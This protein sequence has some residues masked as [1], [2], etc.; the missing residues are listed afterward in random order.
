MPK[1]LW[2][3]LHYQALK[4]QMVGEAHY[5]IHTQTWHK[6]RIDEWSECGRAWLGRGH[7]AR[8]SAGRDQAFQSPWSGRGRLTI[9]RLCRRCFA[10]ELLWLV[11]LDEAM[12]ALPHTR[13]VLDE[14][15]VD[16]DDDEYHHNDGGE[17]VR[18]VHGQ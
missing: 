8:R 10:D 6:G 2:E 16:E 12:K 18:I 5:V 11:P 14:E 9:K 13:A 1:S 17:Q 4:W 15:A 3:W 7:V